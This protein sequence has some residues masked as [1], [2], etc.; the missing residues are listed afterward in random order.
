MH[1]HLLD[2]TSS[3]Q[4]F[5]ARRLVQPGGEGYRVTR[6][7]AHQVIPKIIMLARAALRSSLSLF[8]WFG[9]ETPEKNPK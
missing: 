3:I 9:P 2:V 4:I 1:S 6:V 8:L 5:K 7:L